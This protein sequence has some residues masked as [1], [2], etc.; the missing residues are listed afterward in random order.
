VGL[1]MLDVETEVQPNGESTS[2]SAI[3]KNIKIDTLDFNQ[4]NL[5]DNS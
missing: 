3:H 4:Y 1:Q 2:S 5:K